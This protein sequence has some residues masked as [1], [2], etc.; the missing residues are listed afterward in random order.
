MINVLL[1]FCKSVLAL[2]QRFDLDLTL[3]LTIPRFEE[4]SAEFLT[5]VKEEPLENALGEF[6]DLNFTAVGC[7]IAKGAT[8]QDIENAFITVL[9]KNNAKTLATHHVDYVDGIKKIVRIK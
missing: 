9:R 4:E 8:I 2:Y 1:K 3:D 5:A 7:L 6:G